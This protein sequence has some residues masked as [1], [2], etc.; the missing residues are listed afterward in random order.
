MWTKLYIALNVSGCGE[1]GKSTFIKQMRIIHG[2][3]YN[4]EDKEG[5]KMIVYQNIHM[6]MGQICRAMDEL[7]I[8]YGDESLRVRVNYSINSNSSQGLATKQ[9]NLPT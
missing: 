4:D 8:P 2:C 6:G 9:L 5:F 3:G 7:E 1:S